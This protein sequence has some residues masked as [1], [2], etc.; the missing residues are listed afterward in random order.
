VKRDKK[1]GERKKEHLIQE[2]AGMMADFS[3]IVRSRRME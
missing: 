2:T 1:I 3:E